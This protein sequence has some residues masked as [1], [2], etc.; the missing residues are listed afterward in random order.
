MLIYR[1]PNLRP[2]LQKSESPKKVCG[3]PPPTS[4]YLALLK[5]PFY[6]YCLVTYSRTEAK[7][8]KTSSLKSLTKEINICHAIHLERMGKTVL[9]KD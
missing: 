1:F 7:R 6:R 9:T 5:H 3:N 2:H 8:R 4:G